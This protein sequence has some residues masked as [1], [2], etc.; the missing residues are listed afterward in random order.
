M[1]TRRALGDD[2]KAI[3][4]GSRPAIVFVTHNVEE[5]CYMAGRVV[6]MSRGPGRLVGETRVEG[7][8]PRPASFRTSQTF[9]DACEHV[10][11]DLAT[12]M[13]GAPA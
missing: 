2:V 8:L 9:R 5:A 10:S 1:F 13:Q 12:A 6:V 11:A 7:P 3:W 4:A